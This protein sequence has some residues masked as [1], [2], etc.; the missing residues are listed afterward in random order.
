M[1]WASRGEQ[2]A[3]FTLSFM[4][5]VRILVIDDEEKL[6]R[7]L[8]RTLS[9]EGY[10]V[11]TA[12]TVKSALAVLEEGAVQVVV[13]D[14]KLP[15]GNGVALTQ[16]IKERYPAT[17]VVVLTAYG[18]IADGVQAIRN[19]AFGYLV[20]GDDHDKI[21]PMVSQAADKAKLQFK[22]LELEEKIAQKHSFDRVIGSSPAIQQTLA[23]ARKVAATDTS[24]LLTGETGTGKE[25]FAQAIH[26]AGPRK[27]R[28]FVAVNCSAFGHELLESEMFGHKAGSFTGA[29]KDKRGL[30]EEADGGT[31]FLDEVGEMNLDLQTKLLRVL[32]E[33]TFIKV[34]ETQE[35][36]VNVRV[37]SATNR[38]LEQASEAG[39]FRLDLF[40]RLAVFQVKLPSLNERLEDIPALASYFV[41]TL[42][43]RVGKK[44]RSMH[45]AFSKAL[46]QHFW[47]GNI[48]ELRNVIERCIILTD[49]DQLTPDLL[50]PD[51]EQAP[52]SAQPSLPHSLDLSHVERDH[53]Q[54]VLE[55]TE[56]NKTKTAELLGI[57]LTTLY[58]KIQ[59]YGLQ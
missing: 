13:S 58:R 53:I 48:R 25:V 57:G 9:L 59:E 2:Q 31:I 43:V 27:H 6:R 52:L 1:W 42:S 38:N 50:P 7:L 23:L 22:V 16:T 45:P 40:Y 12:A 39:T 28:Q 32:E 14:V 47:K 17:E 46:Q 11:Q 35:T 18:T 55:R 8:A 44:V 20:K 5:A 56:G 51:F 37:I 41:D 33:G 10:Q 49:T 4:S 34:G 19:G 26:Y 15:D 54:R 21:I 24:V 36:R 3:C 30:L 29:V